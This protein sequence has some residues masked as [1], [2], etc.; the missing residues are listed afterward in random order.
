MDF[1]KYLLHMQNIKI[2]HHLLTLVSG[3]S[4]A[5]FLS[6]LIAPLLARLYAP[7]DFGIFGFYT[8]VSLGLSG[9]ICWQYEV[10]IVLP[11]SNRNAINIMV[12]AI[13]AM[14]ITI[15]LLIGVTILFDN[16]ITNILGNSKILPWLPLIPLHLFLI[17][18]SE[19][20]SYWLM[21]GKSFNSLAAAEVWQAVILNSIQ[22]SAVLLFQSNASGLIGGLIAGQ[23]VAC[24]VLFKRF[25]QQNGFTIIQQPVQPICLLALANKYKKYPLFTT[26]PILLDR[27]RFALPVIL[28]T[29]EFSLVDT[30]F[31]FLCWR[32]LQLPSSIMGVAVGKVLFQ[33]LSEDSRSQDGIAKTISSAFFCLLTITVIPFTILFFFGPALFTLFFGEQWRIAGRMSQILVFSSASQFVV[34]PLTQVFGILNKQELVA[35]WKLGSVLFTSIILSIAVKLKDITWFCVA[36]SVND[37][38]IYSI[39]LM[40][41]FYVSGIKFN[42]LISPQT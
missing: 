10:A 13:S 28:M 24:L 18:F 33:K 34:V 12:L 30:G 20:I 4:L 19:I 37:I 23:F 8:T 36:I 16:Q 15:S 32:L 27:F 26:W 35:V 25:W 41:V 14:L 31:Y 29:Q 9:L 7:E 1:N 3:Y 39:Y 2:I 42:K 5:R 21:R 38:L 22:I 40:L 17:G 6:I 11:K